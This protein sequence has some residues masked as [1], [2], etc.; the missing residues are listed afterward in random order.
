[1]ARIVRKIAK[2]HKDRLEELEASVESTGAAVDA[3]IEAIEWA[4]SDQGA[5]RYAAEIEAQG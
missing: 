1:M 2:V 4:L 5:T 3:H